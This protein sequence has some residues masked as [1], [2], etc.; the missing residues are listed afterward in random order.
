MVAAIGI[1]NITNR[2]MAKNKSMI[3]IMFLITVVCSI[4]GSKQT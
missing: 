2:R 3:V 1:R 4:V